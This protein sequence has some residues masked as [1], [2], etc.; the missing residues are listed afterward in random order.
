VTSAC[1]AWPALRERPADAGLS[2]CG[3]AAA[4]TVATLV[5]AALLRPWRLQAT[6]I[7][8]VLTIWLFPL[9]RRPAPG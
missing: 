2:S 1:R 4:S 7:P 3:V 8:F 5:P 6:T 9:A